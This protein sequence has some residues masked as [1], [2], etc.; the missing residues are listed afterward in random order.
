MAYT[1]V[2]E[3]N[4]LRSA[5]RFAL[6]GGDTRQLYLSQL[7]SEDGHSVSTLALTDTPIDRSV[8]S[9]AT[10]ILLPMPL[11][12]RNGDLYTPLCAE[13]LPL[14]Q[15]LDCFQPNQLIFAGKVDDTA[16]RQAAQRGLIL[17][18]FLLRDE[19]AIANA[20]P[21]A[22][23]ALQLAMEALPITIHQSRVLVLGFGRIGQSTAARFLSLG[24]QV[25]VAARNNAQLALAESFGCTPLPLAQLAS[26]KQVWDL[27]VNTVPAPIL[28]Q[29][30]L[31]NCG[32]ST[33]LEL[34]SPPGGFDMSA[35][36]SLG[37]R[38]I[39]G[40]GLPGKVAP[41]TAARAIQKTLYHMLN[42]LG[43]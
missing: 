1:P 30:M 9:Q 33:L 18:D 25:T 35:V 37:L 29:E 27:I 5:L 41:A 6:V 10:C 2:W 23:G 26:S 40:A 12:D 15:L 4:T 28:T 14:P 36:R 7:L 39:S 32:T 43:F 42:E 16:L 38:Y 34:A 21:T 24:A 31:Q 3:G 19:L 17:H 20:V 8:L 11:L 13:T 22:E